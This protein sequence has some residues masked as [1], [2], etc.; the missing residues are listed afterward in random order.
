MTTLSNVTTAI[1][2]HLNVEERAIQRIEEWS[3][4][5]FVVVEGR[6]PRFVS[7]QILPKFIQRLEE[8]GNRWQKSGQNRIYIEPT[9]LS[10]LLNL[11]R[12]KARQIGGGRF[13]YDV[14]TGQFN[15]SVGTVGNVTDRGISG[16]GYG[17]RHPHWVEA[18]LAAI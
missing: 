5:Y 3:T 1:A 18:V 17:P 13:Y 9:V 2:N 4:V 14:V 6:S 12:S 16:M 11:S 10:Q 15:T 8:I 7:K